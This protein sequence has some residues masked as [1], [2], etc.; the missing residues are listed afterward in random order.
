[1]AYFHKNLTEEK[2]SGLSM[3]KQ[4]LNIGSELIR[5]KTW[6]E[7]DNNDYLKN[8]MDR[9]LELIDL[10]CADKKWR[11]GQLKELLRLREVLGEF[12]VG[13]NKDSG[14]FKSI[15]RGLFKF[16]KISSSVEV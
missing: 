15:I 10:T 2:W 4:I 14:Y 11:H 1:M 16:N 7:E 8:S 3:D 6:L 5:A 12:Y 13:E 9:A